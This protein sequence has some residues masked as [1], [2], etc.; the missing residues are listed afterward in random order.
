MLGAPRSVE[1][2][3]TGANIALTWTAISGLRYRVQ[4][5]ENLSQPEWTDLLATGQTATKNDTLG[6]Q[7]RFYRIQVAVICFRD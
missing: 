5:K 4:F 3:R 6:P 2:S 7:Q 1:V